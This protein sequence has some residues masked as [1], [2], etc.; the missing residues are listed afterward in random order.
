MT[1]TQYAIHC[2]GN[3]QGD[4]PDHYPLTVSEICAMLEAARFA[5]KWIKSNP[6]EGTQQIA[7][8]QVRLGQG[9]PGMICPRP[10]DGEVADRLHDLD[11]A[12]VAWI[13]DPQTMFLKDRDIKPT[14]EIVAR[15]CG[16]MGIQELS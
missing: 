3:H 10:I 11:S 6:E 9:I 4:S 15:L 14:D 1:I 12:Y 13:Q 5:K 8:I 2:D 16:L 7:N